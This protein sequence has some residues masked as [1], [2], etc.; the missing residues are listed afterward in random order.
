MAEGTER[1]WCQPLVMARYR[2]EQSPQG[3]AIELTGVAGREEELLD[4]F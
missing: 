2:I 1:G 4:A 3:I